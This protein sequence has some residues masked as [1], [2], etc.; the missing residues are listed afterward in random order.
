MHAHAA[1]VPFGPI[2]RV[3]WQGRARRRCRRRK[4]GG[5]G[6][7]AGAGGE[8][9]EAQRGAGAGPRGDRDAE[10]AAFKATYGFSEPGGGFV[11]SGWAASQRSHAQTDV[12]EMGVFVLLAEK[13]LPCI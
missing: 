11:R 3:R 8:E 1:C 13:L 9:D 5:A 12:N 10:V 6:A 2:L 4:R 7:G